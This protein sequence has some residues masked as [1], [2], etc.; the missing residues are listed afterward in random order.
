[1][2]KAL[3]VLLV[4]ATLAWGGLAVWTALIQLLA[5][6]APEAAL[7]LAPHS[8]E[9]LLAH[10]QARIAGSDQSVASDTAMVTALLNGAPLSGV[11]LTL[12]AETAIA[13]KDWPAAEALLNEAVR[14]DPRSVRARVWAAY[15]AVSTN[16]PA[17]ALPH[18]ERLLELDPAQSAVYLGA[19]AE[20]SKTPVGRAWLLAFADSGSPLMGRIAKHLNEVSTD[21]ELLLRLSAN[22]PL[23]QSELL[24][25][26]LAV[27]G[28][29]EAFLAWFSFIPAEKNV[30]FT[31]PYNATLSKD[32]APAPFNWYEAP[33]VVSRDD[34]PGINVS[35]DGRT[36]MT[37]LRQVTLIRPG[38]YVLGSAI[39]GNSSERGGSLVWRVQCLGS[40]QV[41]GQTPGAGRQPDLQEVSVSFAIPD[42]GCSAQLLILQGLPGE[43]PIRMRGRVSHIDIRPNAVAPAPAA[44][45]RP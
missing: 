17:Q 44:E 5:Q 32:P 1:M 7:R 25:R 28:P 22:Q 34:R 11:P 9:A 14:R 3:K 23:V 27:E 31:W 33:L 15:V 26:I 12:T 36:E 29:V 4:V 41:I 19:I 8:P 43:F 30:T 16:K 38:A 45:V 18:L 35:Y 37:F 6:R 42:E 2:P 13:R 21:Y 20:A 10:L 40:N 24:N 39:S